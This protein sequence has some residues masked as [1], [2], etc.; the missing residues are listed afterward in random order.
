MKL[1]PYNHKNKYYNWKERNTPIIQG[2]SKENSQIALQYLNDMEK[3]VNIA[4]STAKGS[5]SYIRLNSLREKM[6]FFARRF[7]EVYGLTVMTE[8]T[9]EQLLGFFS[10][11][12]NGRI[13]RKDGKSYKSIAP[14]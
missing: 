7:N 4:S 2:L 3:G 5:R 11:M 12:K 8:I 13:K 9:E 1:D 14:L 6:G 10:D